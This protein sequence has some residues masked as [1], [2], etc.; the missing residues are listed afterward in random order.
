MRS[1]S[2]VFMYTD[3][4]LTESVAFCSRA[5]LT[6]DYC[7][8]SESDNCAQFSTELKVWTGRRQSVRIGAERRARATVMRS[9]TVLKLP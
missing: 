8:E 3:M 7:L 2:E 4:L 5:P 9:L 6:G 1:V